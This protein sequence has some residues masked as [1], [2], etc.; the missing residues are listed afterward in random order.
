MNPRPQL[1]DVLA[2]SGSPVAFNV[3]FETFANPVKTTTPGIEKES[4]HSF[5]H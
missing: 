1:M 3:A 5:I 2:Q 4:D